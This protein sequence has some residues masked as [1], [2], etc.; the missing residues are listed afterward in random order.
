MQNRLQF[1]VCGFGFRSN[2]SLTQTRHTNKTL[3]KR[4]IFG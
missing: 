2:V 4:A 1:K 3:Y